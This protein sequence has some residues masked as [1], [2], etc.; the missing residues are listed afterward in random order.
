MDRNDLSD[1]HTI[2]VGKVLI[3]PVGY[4]P[5]ETPPSGTVPTTTVG[6]ALAG[7]THK[8]KPGECL[9]IIAAQYNVS[10][11]WLVEANSLADPSLIRVGQVLVIP[12]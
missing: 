6:A 5:T 11:R 1:R 10:V 7:R 12:E 2:R 3:I 4:E 8:V 9:S